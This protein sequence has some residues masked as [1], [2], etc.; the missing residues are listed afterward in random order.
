VSKNKL[1]FWAALLFFAALTTYSLL[2]E[3]NRNITKLEQ[4][5]SGVILTEKG[6]G[7]GIVK[8]DNAHILLFDPTT[9]ELVASRNY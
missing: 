8:T 9:L 5:I 1:I 3:I 2:N 6:V 7:G 4:S